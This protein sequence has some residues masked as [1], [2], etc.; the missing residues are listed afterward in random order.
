MGFISV[1]PSYRPIREIGNLGTGMPP[2][3]APPGQVVPPGQAKKAPPP[4]PP[5][6]NLPPGIPNPPSP[7]SQQQMNQQIPAPPAIQ[8]G[9]VVDTTGIVAVPQ[10]QPSLQTQIQAQIQ[11]PVAQPA[12]QQ[13]NSQNNVIPILAQQVKIDSVSGNQGLQLP[14][15]GSFSTLD[16]QVKMDSISQLPPDEGVLPSII[17]LPAPSKSVDP[18]LTTVTTVPILAVTSISSQITSTQ[19]QSTGGALSPAFITGTVSAVLAGV[20][21]VTTIA[22]YLLRSRL[23]RHSPS[24]PESWTPPSPYEKL[25]DPPK[26][27]PELP[28]LATRRFAPTPSTNS[29]KQLQKHPGLYNLATREDSA[30]RS[31]VIDVSPR[32][33]R[34]RDSASTVPVS[35]RESLAPTVV[36]TVIEETSFILDTLGRM[37]SGVAHGA[38]ESESVLT[39]M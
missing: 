39:D 32:R 4:P 37:N 25:S 10:P 28:P 1:C 16:Q 9:T 19:V 27:R 3:I 31:P 29:L 14:Q 35:Q 5:N 20:I 6:I 30:I 21:V 33:S 11:Q 13:L 24:D 15:D 18:K 34:F 8:D 7:K 17:N 2:K 12:Q 36:D 26:I 38:W 22:F 23:R